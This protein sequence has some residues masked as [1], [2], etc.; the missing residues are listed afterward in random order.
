MPMFLLHWKLHGHNALLFGGNSDGFGDGTSLNANHSFVF[1]ITKVLRS[2]CV[3]IRTWWIVQTLA[4]VYIHSLQRLCW[5]TD[6]MP[7]HQAETRS[8]QW[9]T[10]EN[11]IGLAGE[12]R[13][14]YSY[15]PYRLQ[16]KTPTLSKPPW[17]PDAVEMGMGWGMVLC[18]YACG[19]RRYDGRFKINLAMVIVKVPHLSITKVVDEL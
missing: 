9:Q 16:L 14:E 19:S 15:K 4:N 10:Y 13:M 2:K 17:R 18:T 1:L 12:E 5:S 3:Q 7:P 8:F 11:W 6:S